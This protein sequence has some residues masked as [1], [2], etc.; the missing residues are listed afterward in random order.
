MKEGSEPS[1]NSPMLLI[2]G[3]PLQALTNIFLKYIFYVPSFFM[4]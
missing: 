4:H 1:G 3:I 2:G